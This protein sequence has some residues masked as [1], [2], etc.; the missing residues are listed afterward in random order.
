MLVLP[1][2]LPATIY[3]SPQINFEGDSSV[4]VQVHSR[5]SMHDTLGEAITSAIDILSSFSYSGALNE[6]TPPIAGFDFIINDIGEDYAIWEMTPFDSSTKL[7]TGWPILLC[8]LLYTLYFSDA[9][10]IKQIDF[11]TLPTENNLKRVKVDVATE[12]FPMKKTYH[13]ILMMIFWEHFLIV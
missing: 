3:A 2:E 9:E 10:E 11:F 6:N 1:Y 4:F 13:L 8:N 5:E 12:I 7:V